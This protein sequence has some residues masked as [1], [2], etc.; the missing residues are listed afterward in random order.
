MTKPE[1]MSKSDMAF[2]LYCEDLRLEAERLAREAELREQEAHLH[3]YRFGQ[4]TQ[5]VRD[6]ERWTIDVMIAFLLGFAV[7][8][9]VC[10]MMSW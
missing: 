9:V 8:V 10:G 5:A 7:A 1:A 2:E 3:A 4:S 6:R